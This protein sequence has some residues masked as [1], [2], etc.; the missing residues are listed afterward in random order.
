MLEK[1][2]LIRGY[3]VSVRL[4][5]APVGVGHAAFRTRGQGRSG[6]GGFVGRAY[7]RLASELE[8]TCAD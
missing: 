1:A 5:S 7:P 8:Q 2:V 6:Q 4:V 3:M